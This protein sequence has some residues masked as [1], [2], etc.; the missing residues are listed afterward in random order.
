VQ[1]LEQPETSPSAQ[2]LRRDKILIIDDQ[3]ELLDMYKEW[4]SNLPSRPEVHASSTG[5]RAIALLESEPFDLLVTDLRM[6]KMDGLQVLAIVRRKFPSLRL[7][8]LTGVTDEAYR[9]RAYAMGVDLF[10]QKPTTK[11]EAQGFEACIESLL[12]REKEAG[13]F[14]GVQ[15]KSL[16]DIIQ[17]ECLSQGSSVLRIV[18]HALEGKIWVMAGDVIDAMTG[19]F[20]GEDAFKEIM[21]WKTGTFEI[22]PAELNRPRSIHSSYQ[23]LLLDSAQA[24]DESHNTE[25]LT[26]SDTEVVQATG[27]PLAKLARFEGVEFVLESSNDNQP[28]AYAVENAEV[29]AGWAKQTRERLKGI[30]NL[31]QAGFLGQVQG[32]GL[33]RHI[34]I[35]EHEK[36]TLCIGFRRDMSAEQVLQ[37]TKQVFTKWVS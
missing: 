10:C 5:A 26:K 31:I 20:V 21:S 34:S 24:I 36:G 35:S 4:L 8:V 7:V 15:S 16:M 17:L 25:F 9:S 30:G 23:G 2:Q 32:M 14:R 1:T 22:L 13:G 19:S 12:G 3:Q 27:S 33:Q 6:P 28:R 29:L 37:T 18:H 11:E